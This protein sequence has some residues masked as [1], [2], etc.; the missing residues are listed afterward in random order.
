LW[1]TDPTQVTVLGTQG[2]QRPPAVVSHW[3]ADAHVVVLS[4]SPSE[5]QLWR[6]ALTHV[7]ELGTQTPVQLPFEQT[8]GHAEPF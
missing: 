5:E 4:V 8:K 3:A 1:S 6:T 7:T 2:S